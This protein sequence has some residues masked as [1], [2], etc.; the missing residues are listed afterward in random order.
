[1]IC[2]NRNLLL[3]GGS[4]SPI[5]RPRPSARVA[6]SSEQVIILVQGPPPGPMG[7]PGAPPPGGPGPMPGAPGSPGLTPAQA[8]FQH[9]ASLQHEVAAIQ[10]Q[11]PNHPPWE[12]KEMRR[13]LGK[14]DTN[15]GTTVGDSGRECGGP[16]GGAIEPTSAGFGDGSG[17]LSALIVA[18][19]F[20]ISHWPAHSA[21]RN[22]PTY[23]I[24]ACQPG[25][26]SRG[27]EIVDSR[28]FRPPAEIELQLDWMM[29]MDV[30]GG[31]S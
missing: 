1:M 31:A 2:K 10:G 24:W 20:I 30:A 7:P 23:C 5:R 8:H 29:G 21:S 14:F 6:P 22:A 13:H 26:R 11:L 28:G 4:C 16:S 9:C 3:A 25:L 18:V 15:S 17:E 27:H 19:A 12:R